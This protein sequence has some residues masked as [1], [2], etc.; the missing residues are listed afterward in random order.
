[1]V[2]QTYALYPHKTVAGNMGYG[3]KLAGRPKAEIEAEVRKVARVLELE[4]LLARK[5][6]E[7][8]GG[9]RQRV[10]I[11]RA[12]VR[13]PKVFLFDEPLSNLDA[14]LRGQMRIEIADLHSRLGATMIYVTHDQIEAMT[15]ADRIVVLNKGRIEQQG[16]P[17][18]LYH[19]PVN[20]F[21][22]GFLGAPK[23]NFIPAKVIAIDALGVA[24]A[25]DGFG[26]VRLPVTGNVAKGDA[27]TFGIRPHDFRLVGGD[28]SCGVEVGLSEPLGHETVLYGTLAGTHHRITAA[29]DGAASLRAGEKATLFYNAADAYLFDAAGIALRRAPQNGTDA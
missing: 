23:M 8:S 26:A 9:Q 3:L 22:A 29:V 11:G 4:S 1:M 18:E 20:M 2:F 25:V 27:V 14:A 17:L 12:I 21:V 16:R 7:L 28:C 5:P 6:S 10:A 19:H 15:M 13:N 24:L